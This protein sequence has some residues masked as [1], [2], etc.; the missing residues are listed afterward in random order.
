MKNENDTI[1]PHGGTLANR[2]A[3]GEELKEL[4]GKSSK[5]ISLTVSKRVLCDLEMIAIGAF[6]PLTGFVDEK[7]YKSI[8]ENMRLNNGL[9][10]PIP[11]TLQVQKDDYEKIKNQK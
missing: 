1:T 2:F 3:K 7:D 5:L 9:I 4:R 6:S 10:W 11:I 8:V